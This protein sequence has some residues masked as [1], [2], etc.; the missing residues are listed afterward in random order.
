MI[1]KLSAKAGDT[2]DVSSIPQSGRT[3]GGGN[4]NPLQYSC[5]GNPIDRGAWRVAAHEVA[6]S[7]TRL[8]DWARAWWGRHREGKENAMTW[9]KLVGLRQGGL[10][11]CSSWH[12]KESDRTEQLNWTELNWTEKVLWRTFLQWLVTFILENRDVGRVYVE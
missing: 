3:H 12:R 1:K 8:S 9:A 2:G 6:E 5:L 11:C 7:W 10:V 4:G